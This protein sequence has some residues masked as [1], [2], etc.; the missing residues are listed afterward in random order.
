MDRSEWVLIDTETNGLRNPILPVELAAQR[1]RGW[2]RNGPPFRR[3][4]NQNADLTPEASR[5]NGYT[6]EILERDGE[7][8]D[9][10]YALF[11]AYAGDLPIVSFNL[12]FDYDQ[13]LVPEW[14]RR[15]LKPRA[16]RG[17]CSF[18]SLSPECA[19]QTRGKVGV[20]TRSQPSGERFAPRLVA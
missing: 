18:R 17:L 20:F 14:Q 16:Q 3:L 19:G 1:M 13:V 5:V 12:G 11:D 15:G 2:E 10:V 7:D 4:L 9:A 6:R 8:P